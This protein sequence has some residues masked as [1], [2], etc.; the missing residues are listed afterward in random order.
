MTPLGLLFAFNLFTGI[1][2]GTAVLG[3]LVD[4]GLDNLMLAIAGIGLAMV[5]AATAGVRFGSSR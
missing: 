2:V 1:A 4:A 3:R 5:G